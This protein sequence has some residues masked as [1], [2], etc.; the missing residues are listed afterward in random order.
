MALT[1]PACSADVPGADPCGRC[2]ALVP[3]SSSP[4][5]LGTDVRAVYALSGGAEPSS[6]SRRSAGRAVLVAA[7]GLLTV[8]VAGAAVYAGTA[9]GGGGTQPEDVLPSGAIGFVKVDFDPAA[10]QKLAAYRLAQ[11][12]PDSGVTGEDSLRDDLFGGLLDGED[13][14]QYEDHVAPWIGQRAGVAWLPPGPEDS[15][16]PRAVV[17]VQVTD[18]DAAQDGLTALRDAGTVAAGG[19]EVLWEFTADGDYVLLSQER[20]VLDAAVDAP[21]HLADDTRF[22]DA[23]AA[24]DGDQVALGW[25]D[26]EGFWGALP[27][28]ERERAAQGTPGLAPEGTVVVGAHVEDDGVEVVG[29]SLDVSVGDAPAVQALLDNSFG[30]TPPDGLVQQLP[31]DSAVAISLTGVGEGLSELWEAQGEEAA[32]DPQVAELVDTYGLPLPEDLSALFGSELAV[33]VG[34]D[35]T[36][37]APRVDVQVTTADPDRALELVEAARTAAAQAQVPGVGAVEVERLDDGY[38]VHSPTGDES[39]AGELGDLELF[40][41]TV[42]DVETSGA[43]YYVDVA[44]VVEGTGGSEGLT[45]QM[46]RN[47]EPVKAVGWTASMQDGGDGTFRLRVTIE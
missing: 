37:G 31:A 44:R 9:L 28:Q 8:G 11:Q 23:V 24:L 3:S 21:E 29:R 43:T 15:D 32:A 35:L 5:V 16:T 10:G 14:Q 2:G 42:P 22:T 20:S 34:G 38:A 40:S 17:A 26:V 30:R 13:A 19:S 36:G 45:E 6:G 46:R 7:A 1:C 27:E 41:R 33:G 25:L 18:R 39:G 47:L 12:F 4:D